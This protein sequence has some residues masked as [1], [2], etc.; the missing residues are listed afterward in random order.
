MSL[1]QTTLDA[2][3]LVFLPSVGRAPSTRRAT[4]LSVAGTRQRHKSARSR[5]GRPQDARRGCAMDG[6][7]LKSCVIIASIGEICGLAVSLVQQVQLRIFH[8]RRQFALKL[9]YLF[10]KC[11]DVGKT[12]IHGS[13]SEIGHL[14]HSP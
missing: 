13:K 11:P 4:M 8:L 9:L 12:M 14:V 3:S 7:H 6:A 1:L 5:F 10:Q 2:P